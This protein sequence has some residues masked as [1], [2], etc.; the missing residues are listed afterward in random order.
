[1]VNLDT[2]AYSNQLRTDSLQFFLGLAQKTSNLG[3]LTMETTVSKQPATIGLPPIQPIQ[4]LKS[5]CSITNLLHIH[6]AP[7]QHDHN[8][9]LKTGRGG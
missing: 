1:M 5:W 9:L 6:T 2:F 8:A 4:F 7:D 3:L